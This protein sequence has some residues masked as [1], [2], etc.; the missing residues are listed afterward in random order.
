MQKIIV[1]SGCDLTEEMKNGTI[2]V[3]VIPLNLQLGEKT[4]V[5][6]INLDMAK[7]VEDMESCTEKVQTSAPSPE[8]FL[9]AYKKEGSVFIVTLSSKLSGTYNSA[10]LAKQ[11]YLDE[12]GEKF[13][14]IVD[15]LSAC[16]GETVIALRI[17]ECIK[18]NFSDYEIVEAINKFMSEMRT[19]FI[20]EKLDNLVKNGRIKPY[21]AKIAT[22]LSIKVIGG[23]KNGEIEMVDKARGYK[24]AVARLVDIIQKDNLDFENRI[25]GIT[26]VQCLER[27]LDMKAEIL[28]R[29]KFKDVVICEARGIAST[30]A[31]KGG[32]V[33]SY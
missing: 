29:I 17:N 28:K 14:H 24:R 4:F 13:I 22:L 3:E 12:V 27:A 11:M 26:H 33:L 15:S 21:I 10:L 5:D 7:Y 9:E 30:Y 31:Q 6:D 2:E 20:L 32:L 25:L 8:L 23:A 19:I 18:N 16:V 1:D